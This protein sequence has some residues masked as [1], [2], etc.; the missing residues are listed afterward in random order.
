MSLGQAVFYKYSW[1]SLQHT[2]STEMHQLRQK[3]PPAQSLVPRRGQQQMCYTGVQTQGKHTVAFMQNTPPRLFLGNSSGTGS[4]FY[5]KSRGRV[6]L[7]AFPKKT[8]FPQSPL[9]PLV[10]STASDSDPQG[11][12]K[13]QQNQAPE[14]PRRVK[15]TPQHPVLLS[16]G[17]LLCWL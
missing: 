11:I 5:F 8:G 13:Q 2:L 7:P 6:F 12:T 14:W 15:L 9:L 16:V 4:I 10:T 1:L 3:V 17:F